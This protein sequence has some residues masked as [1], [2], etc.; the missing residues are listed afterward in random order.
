[1]GTEGLVTLHRKLCPLQK[2]WQCQSDCS[3]HIVRRLVTRF[4]NNMADTHE[5][6]MSSATAI[7]GYSRVKPDQMRPV[8]SILE[9]NDVF[10][11]LPTGT[12]KS[13]CYATIAIMTLYLLKHWDDI[14]SWIAV[15][16]HRQSTFMDIS[17]SDNTLLTTSCIN[18]HEY[19]HGHDAYI[20]GVMLDVTII[21]KLHSIRT[22]FPRESHQTFP[23]HFSLHILP[24]HAVWK[25]WPA[26]LEDTIKHFKQSA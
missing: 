21:K 10:V 19:G 5:V 6:L 15:E 22:R 24:K 2:S 26:R 23:C 1:M 25:V 11:C 8:R 7:L 17:K 16:S 14:P 13:L 9:E 4:T 18:I 12:G 3:D 20:N